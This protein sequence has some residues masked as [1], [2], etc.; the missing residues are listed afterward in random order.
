MARRCKREK[1]K[2][3][4]KLVKHYAVRR[5]ELRAKIR[6][7]ELSPEEKFKVQEQMQAL[8]RDSNPCRLR[9]R[10]LVTG[11][12]RGVYRKFGLSRHKLRE[13]AMVGIIPGL[14]MASW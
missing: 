4:E 1:E 3:R 13:Y 10:C 6:S 8:P 2:V 9:N 7:T 14:R 5:T 11:R 12:A